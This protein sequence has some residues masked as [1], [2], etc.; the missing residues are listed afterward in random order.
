[1]GW[2]PLHVHSQYSILDATASV[3][4]LAAKAKELGMPALALTDQ[5]NMYGTVEF[6]K[7]CQGVGIKPIIGCELHVAP[8]SRHEKKRI[9]GVPAGFPLILLVKNKQGYQNLCKLSSL[10]HIEGFYY[11]PRIDFE[12]LEKHAEGLICLSGPLQGKLAYL[13]IQGREEEAV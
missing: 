10:A 8:G 4:D 9:P 12:L 1:M 7:A 3:E 5:G 13:I 2:I 11:T 6:Y